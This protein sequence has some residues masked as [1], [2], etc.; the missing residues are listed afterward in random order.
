MMTVS[1]TVRTLYFFFFVFI[2]T[3]LRTFVRLGLS[4]RVQMRDWQPGS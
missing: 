4:Q 1:V 2:D 3:L